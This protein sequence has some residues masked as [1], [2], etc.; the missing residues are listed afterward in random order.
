MTRKGKESCL[1]MLDAVGTCLN[2]ADLSHNVGTAVLGRMQESSQ[3]GGISRFVGTVGTV[4]TENSVPEKSLVR[5][6]GV[7]ASLDSARDDKRK[8]VSHAD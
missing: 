7:E 3:F 8:D 4:G 2:S 1:N 5:L 6:S